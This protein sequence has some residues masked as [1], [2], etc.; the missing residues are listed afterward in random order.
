MQRRALERCQNRVGASRFGRQQLPD[1]SHA[2]APSVLI[3][4]S[5]QA[6]REG[7][8]RARDLFLLS[9]LRSHE[10]AAAGLDVTYDALGVDGPMREHLEDALLDLVPVRGLPAVEAMSVSAMLAGV[11]V[12]LLIADSALPV[13][14]LDL[15]V[16]PD[17]EYRDR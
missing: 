17:N 8:D 7:C 16:T 2:V 12:G 11:L 1:L 14:E 10:E 3:H 13:D 15:P 5:T 6:L 4:I 9:R